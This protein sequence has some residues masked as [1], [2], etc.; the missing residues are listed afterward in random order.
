MEQSGRL[1]KEQFLEKYKGLVTEEDLN[2]LSFDYFN[3]QY[4]N[5][6]LLPKSDLKYLF[7]DL[8]LGVM[9][10]VDLTG[11]SK[12]TI[13]NSQK[14]YNIHKPPKLVQLV[15]ERMLQR[16]YGIINVS[17]MRGIQ[18][19]IKQN[20]LQKY[21]VDNPNALQ[22]I[23]NKIKETNLK[24][25]GVDNYAKTPECRRL[26][27]QTCIKRYGVDNYSKT[28]EFQQRM[29]TRCQNEYGV[30]YYLQVKELREKGKDTS[31]RKYG[32]EHPMQ[33][34]AVQDLVRESLKSHGTFRKSKSEEYAFNKLKEKFTIVQRQYKDERYPFACDFYIPEEDL[35]IELQIYQG[36]GGHP[37]NPMS[38]EDINKIKT[39][40]TKS[41]EI[42]KHGNPKLQYKDYIKI[43]TI[44]DPNKRK[45]AKKNNLN[46]MEFFNLRE[47]NR[48]WETL[49]SKAVPIQHPLM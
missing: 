33:S 22:V 13:K 46:W 20:N 42:N 2:K 36:H 5:R 39:W 27:A 11:V 32:T 45:I 17:Q 15:R 16:K 12:Y 44:S 14:K 35:F 23:K 8:N 30:D 41:K 43:W 29:K 18:E 48:W 9:E 19:K 10:I 47:F 34:Q 28:K 24:K 38:E 3:E 31:L 6:T 1:T 26:M 49:P 37:F 40:Q 25:Y 4:P 7:L 21:G